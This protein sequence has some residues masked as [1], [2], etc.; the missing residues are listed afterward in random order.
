MKFFLHSA[1]ALAAV[2]LLLLIPLTIWIVRPVGQVRHVRK[3]RKAKSRM[4]HL[5]LNGEWAM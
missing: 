3:P 1:A 5:P 4:F 2:L